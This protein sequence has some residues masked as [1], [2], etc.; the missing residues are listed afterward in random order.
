MRKCKSKNC[1]RHFQNKSMN[2]TMWATETITPPW[3]FAGSMILS[4]F[5]REKRK[6]TT[7]RR[8]IERRSREAQTAAE[9]IVTTA[10]FVVN[11]R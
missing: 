4:P 2:L 10:F 6:D 5:S 9:H 3:L 7:T 8:F 1:T 11:Y